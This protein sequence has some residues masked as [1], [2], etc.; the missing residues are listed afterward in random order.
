MFA[1]DALISFFSGNAE[2]ITE[3]SVLISISLVIIFAAFFAY[4]SKVLKQNFILAYVVSGIILGPLVLGIISDKNL[5]NG[6]AEI[7]ISFLLFTIG[8]EMGFK[9]LKESFSTSAIAGII[10]VISVTLFCFFILLAFKF[11]VSEAVWIGLAISFSST[12]VVTKILADKNELNTLHAR[13]II[14]IMLVQDVIAIICLAVLTKEFTLSFIALTLIKLAFL[15]LISFFLYFILRK[16]LKKIASSTELLFIISLALLFFLVIL[17]SLLNFSITIGAFIAGIIFANTAYK[18]EIETR[19]KSLRDFFSVIF[20]VSVGMLLTNISRGMLMPT[21]FLLLVLIIF[22]PLITALVLRFK[23]Y[24]SRISLKIGVSFAQLS[25]FSLIL[26]LTALNFGVIPQNAFDIII[27]TTVISIAITPY[28][29]KLDKPFSKIFGKVFDLIPKKFSREIKYITPGKKKIIIFGCHRMG[30]IYLQFLEKVKDRVLVV[31]FNPEVINSLSIKKI[32]CIYGDIN[33]RE[34]IQSLPLNDAEIFIST[35]PDKQDNILL[36]RCIRNIKPDALIALTAE[37]IHDALEM[38]EKGADY[39]IL[40]QVL[41]A[42]KSLEIFTK[43]SK[44]KNFKQKHIAYLKK[45]HN[46]LY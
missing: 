24:N 20:F 36:I 19:T 38:Y 26:M 18:L 2:S 39:V 29:I 21:F 45:I 34:F 44:I 37:K 41:G 8:L 23:G 7:G 40:P 33:N 28:T 43:R 17:A 12:V 1:I 14:G 9:K 35:I 5:I 3:H 11:S 25:E 10:Q 13:F 30:S 6:F 27:L 4:L 15:L 22:E 32:S 31:D 42:E 46:F 16:T